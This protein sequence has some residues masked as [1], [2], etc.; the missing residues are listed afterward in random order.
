MALAQC[1]PWLEGSQCKGGNREPINTGPHWP[2]GVDGLSMLSQTN[3]HPNHLIPAPVS[4]I[5]AFCNCS[6]FGTRAKQVLTWGIALLFFFFFV[7]F[8]VSFA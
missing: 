6:P 5:L 8:R 4:I 3:S 7:F 2:S 1:A